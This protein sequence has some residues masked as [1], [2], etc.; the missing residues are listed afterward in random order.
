MSWYEKNRDAVLEKQK[1]YYWAN[2]ERYRE[3]QKQYYIDVLK[4]Q[5]TLPP[6]PPKPPKEKKVKEPKPPKEK[7]EK[8]WKDKTIR[9]KAS[10][11]QQPAIIIREG[12]FTLTFN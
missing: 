6:R 11:Y 2:R 9:K 5:R 1:A 12:N 8:V 4:A 7:K 3:Y 10:D